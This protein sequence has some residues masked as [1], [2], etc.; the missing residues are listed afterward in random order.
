MPDHEATFIRL[1]N[2]LVVNLACLFLF[3]EYPDVEPTN[4]RSEHNVRREAETR[5]GGR[6]SKTPKGAKRPGVI[7]AVLA[8]L[9]TRFVKF[10]LDG[11]LSEVK[12]WLAEGRSIF[13]LE[14]DE[15]QRAN[16]PP[17]VEPAVFH[18]G[19]EP[20]PRFSML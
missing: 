18:G 19:R 12:T 17:F 8:S 9:R 1:Q 16:A 5:K 15:L 11:L 13:E 6:T 10:T 14:L 20:L 3:V 2:E 7:M 4:N